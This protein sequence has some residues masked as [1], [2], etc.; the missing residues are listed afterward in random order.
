MLIYCIASPEA[1]WHRTTTPCVYLCY[2]NLI[3][4]GHHQKRECDT[5][6]FVCSLVSRYR[7]DALALPPICLRATL[8]F[9]DRFLPCV[10][11]TLVSTRQSRA[12]V[13]AVL[14]LCRSLEQ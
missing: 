10:T 11:N 2:T 1:R 7:I 3:C 5:N 8:R 9:K 4:D 6:F 14:K 13:Q 12:I